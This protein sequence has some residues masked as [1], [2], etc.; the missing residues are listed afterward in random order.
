MGVPA[1]MKQAT[2]NLFHDKRRGDNTVKLLVT[3]ERKQKLF[4]TGHKVDSAIWDRLKKNADKDS[5]DGKIKD[6]DFLELWVKLWNRPERYRQSEPVGVVPYARG[7]ASKLG[8]NF[9][10]E[11]FREAFERH[12]KEEALSNTDE[13][14]VCAALVAKGAAMRKEGRVGNALSYELT[15]KSF[16][17]FIDS[18]SV[19]EQR[20]FLGTPNSGKHIKDRQV[21]VLRFHHVTSDFLKVYEQWMLVYGKSPKNREKSATA[22][23]LTTV[24][25]YCRHLRSIFNDAIA[26]NV[27]PNHYYPFG[28]AGYTIPAGTN[29]KKAISKEE[30]GK[31][32]A[33]IPPPESMMQRSLDLWVFSYLSNGMNM[34]DICSLRWKDLDLSAKSLV[35]VRQKTTRARKGNQQIIQVHLFDESLAIIERWGDK[36]NKSAGYVF[37]FL[38]DNMSPERKKRVVQQ[39]TKTTNYNMKQIAD[40]L[41]INRA[42][43]T[44]VARHSFVTV[45]LQSGASLAYIRE[46]VGHAST[47]TTEIYAGS[48]ESAETHQLLTALLPKPISD[49]AK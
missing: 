16:R 4:S 41:G 24:G 3:F 44:Y 38:D 14:D 39:V 2:V 43:G 40:K 47:R 6:E 19:E 22:A 48:L 18:F 15:A 31:I 46:K 36:S 12:G 45:L 27:I 21:P 13:N 17:R 49:E 42:V 25:I 23:S 1:I 32:M 7:I 33:F 20:E 8:P 9:T 34:T 26:A 28:K 30:I 35:F 11:A 29:I 37:P 10:F 5:P